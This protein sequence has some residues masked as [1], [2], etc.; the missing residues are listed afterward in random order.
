MGLVKAKQMDPPPK[1]L[2][3]FL[4][5]LSHSYLET[6]G[7]STKLVEAFWDGDQK[8]RKGRFIKIGLEIITLA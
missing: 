1:I 7:K 3:F 8:A 4:T 6:Q 2:L 5:S